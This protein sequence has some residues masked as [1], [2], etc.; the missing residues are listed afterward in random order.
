MFTPANDASWALVGP[1]ARK[2]MGRVGEG[3]CSHGQGAGSQHCA[4]ENATGSFHLQVPPGRYDTQTHGTGGA[5]DTTSKIHSVVC[6]ARTHGKDPRPGRRGLVHARRGRAAPDR[7]SWQ[8]VRQLLLAD[9]GRDVGQSASPG[10]EREE[11]TLSRRGR[12]WSWTTNHYAPP[13]PYVAPDP[14]VPYTVCA[15]E[16]ETEQMVVLGQLATGADAE[17]SSIGME[18]ELVL[19]PLFEDDEHEYVVWQWA[20]RPL[21]GA[22]RASDRDIAVLGVGMHPWGKWGRNFV[23]YGVVAAQAALADAGVAWTDIQFVSGGETV[24]NGYPGYVAGR[25]VRASAGLERRAGRVVVRRVRIRRDCAVDGAGA[26]PRRALRRRARHRRR[27]HTEGF[28][29]AEQGRARRR[30]RLAALPAA[31]RD[32]PDLLRPVR[33]PAHGAVRRDPRGLRAQSR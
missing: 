10:E 22:R 5:G 27:H 19:G 25:D 3:G 4:D 17:C 13:E 24:R 8:G 32:E 9:D 1:S 16:L 11:A 2:Q 28:P 15:V 29:R 26:D 12:L 31:R 33:A 21:G 30:S 20:A 7:R 23:E 18:M 6:H 14:F